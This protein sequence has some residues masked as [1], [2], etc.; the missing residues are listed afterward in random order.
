M[1]KVIF[2]NDEYY[3]LV[4]R[5]SIKQVG[6]NM[7]GLKAWRDRNHCDRVLKYQG[8]YLLVRTVEEAKIIPNESVGS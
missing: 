8:E 1:V 7:E 3:Q 4:R 2:L 6:D 5:I